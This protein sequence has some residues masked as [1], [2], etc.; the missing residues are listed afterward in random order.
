MRSGSSTA[1]RRSPTRVL[2]QGAAAGEDA[3]AKNGGAA[4][5]DGQLRWS[6]AA[7]NRL[8]HGFQRPGGIDGVVD[9]LIDIHVAHSH[10]EGQFQVGWID[11]SDGCKSGVQH[12]LGM[13]REVGQVAEDVHRPHILQPHQY[14]G[15]GRTQAYPAGVVA[16]DELAHRAFALPHGGPGFHLQGGAEGRV[17]VEADLIAGDDPGEAQRQQLAQRDAEVIG[18][19]GGGILQKVEQGNRPDPRGVVGLIDMNVIGLAE[20]DVQGFSL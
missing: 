12:P 16:D 3:V 13:Q 9:V 20:Q 15:G 10:P 18:M 8:R 5:M 17:I 19:V 6:P 7:E 1:A 14:P 4:K 11:G 2:R